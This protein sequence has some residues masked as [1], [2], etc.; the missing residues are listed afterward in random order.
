MKLFTKYF[1]SLFICFLIISSSAFSQTKFNFIEH[2]WE[3]F[4]KNKAFDDEDSFFKIADTIKLIIEKQWGFFHQEYRY[5]QYDLKNQKY[6]TKKLRKA[7]FHYMRGLY[8][9][10][11]NLF[12][13]SFE[14]FQ[15]SRNMFQEIDANL[16]VFDCYMMSVVNSLYLNDLTTAFKMIENAKKQI[17]KIDNDTARWDR[18]AVLN[19]NYGKY[20]LAF[21]HLDKAKFH[22][23]SARRLIDFLMKLNCIY[24]VEW[25][26]YIVYNTLSKYY[27]KKG[28]LDSAL[29]MFDIINNKLLYYSNMY[30]DKYEE[31][32]K[33]YKLQ[34]DYKSIIQKVE[35]LFHY[36]SNMLSQNKDELILIAKLYLYDDLADAYYN[37]GEKDKAYQLLKE[38][39]ELIAKRNENI[40]PLQAINAKYEL[41]G[42]LK[43]E[44]LKQQITYI[45]FA[46]I[47]LI[48]LISVLIYYNRFQKIRKL[49]LKLN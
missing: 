15:I 43:E 23:D 7:I 22:L 3:L 49:N 32:C 24:Q 14:E 33:I 37:V 41:E 6:D 46:S 36:Y 34:K 40:K 45:L 21:N 35:Y 44:E 30:A 31:I 29:M 28:L 8:F 13:K 9:S 47:T 26:Y 42:K 39:N 11:L 25:N 19:W 17:N 48:I 1:F 18:T 12:S 4:E 38:L 10:Q 2:F 27:V 5:F 16:Y 20:Y